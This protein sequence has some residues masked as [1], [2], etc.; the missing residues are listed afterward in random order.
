MYFH[1]TQRK[2]KVKKQQLQLKNE[3]DGHKRLLNAAVEKMKRTQRWEPPEGIDLDIDIARLE[4]QVQ[5]E[6]HDSPDRRLKREQEACEREEITKM[7]AKVEE[8]RR[9]KREKEA[10]E[11]REKKREEDHRKKDQEAQEREA[12]KKAK[13]QEEEQEKIREE[14]RLRKLKK[15]EEEHCLPPAGGRIRFPRLN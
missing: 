11:E 4:R 7:E 15:R 13:A 12:S 9:Q 6:M 1:V 2:E 3:Q 5:E 10:K 8:E 14:E